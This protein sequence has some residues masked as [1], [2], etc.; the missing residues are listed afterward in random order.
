M[1]YGP[2]EFHEEWVV[3][4]RRIAESRK[5][6]P[7]LPAVRRLPPPFRPVPRVHTGEVIITLDSIMKACCEMAGIGHGD[8][9]STSRLLHIADARLVYY[10][11][12]KTMMPNSFK[13]I[14]RHCGCRDHTT[15]MS[16][17]QRVSRNLEDYA[18]LINAV[19]VQ[20]E[21]EI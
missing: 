1:F 19:K 13:G 21:V 17:V 7:K 5:K 9:I 15:V 10:Y 6:A 16:G 3:K 8:I 2:P 14:A 18:E 4:R 12:A 11:L 20:L